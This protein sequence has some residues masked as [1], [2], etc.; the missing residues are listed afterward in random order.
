M[1]NLEREV[2]QLC[3]D[4]LT[5]E[6]CPQVIHNCKALLLEALCAN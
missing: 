3:P 5:P 2:R 6:V 4:I 1:L